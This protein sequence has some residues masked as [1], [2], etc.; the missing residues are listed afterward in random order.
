MNSTS[1]AND[2]SSDERRVIGSDEPAEQERR[3][4][5]VIAGIPENRRNVLRERL[6]HDHRS[7]MNVLTHLNVE[8]LQTWSPISR[9]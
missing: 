7:V 1:I 5:I 9:S 2:L 4:S 8:C 3:R 6:I